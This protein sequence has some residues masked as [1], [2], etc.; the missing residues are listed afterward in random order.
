MLADFRF[1]RHPNHKHGLALRRLQKRHIH[2]LSITLFHAVRFMQ[3]WFAI[4]N[5]LSYYKLAFYLCQANARN[6]SKE[7]F[8]YV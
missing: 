5:R 1:R 6:F 7:I 2:R 3:L 4:C 8:E